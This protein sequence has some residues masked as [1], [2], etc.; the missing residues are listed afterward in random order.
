MPFYAGFDLGGTQLKYGLIDEN[1]NIISQENVDT[2]EK[3]TDLTALIKI[4]WEKLKKEAGKPIETVGFGFPGIFSTVKQKILQSPNYPGIDNFDL[5]S[6]L[7]E[8]IKVPF[9]VGNDANMAAFGEYKAGAGKG[10]HS[11]ILLTI[12]TGVGGGVVLEGKLWQGS[13]GFAGEIGHII[14]NPE[15]ELCNC[16]SRG[17]LETEGSAPKIIRNYQELKPTKENL[18]AKDIAMRAKQGDK[19]ATEAFTRAGRFL[20]IG[21]GTAINLFNPEKVVLGGGVMKAGDLLLAPTISEARKRSFKGSFDCCSIVPASLGN[22]AGF[23][24]AA[25]WARERLISL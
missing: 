19:A 21:I 10:A 4:C 9:I 12:G 24:G 22:K 11:M 7:S 8:F 15:G 2:P 16:G 18:S 3:I 14:V 20:G 23:I 1:L 6:A 17:C 13:G 5:L 25:C